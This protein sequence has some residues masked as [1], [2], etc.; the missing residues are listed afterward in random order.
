MTTAL[1]PKTTS[2]L[3][4]K[5]GQSVFSSG[6]HHY[7]YAFLSRYVDSL[8]GSPSVK[9]GD[10]S[11]GYQRLLEWGKRSVYTDL[12]SIC[13][14]PVVFFPDGVHNP[15]LI[16]DHA[17]HTWL[18]NKGRERVTDSD[19]YKHKVE[20]YP[21]L[22]ELSIEHFFFQYI[23]TSEIQGILQEAIQDI[24]KDYG[25][26][27]SPYKY[28]S[29]ITKSAITDT[30]YKRNKDFAP[31]AFQCDTVDH[32]AG[33]HLAHQNVGAI[34][35]LSAPTRSGKSHMG[36]MI[37]KEL[38]HTQDTSI[39][40]IVSGIA[41]VRTEWQA[42]WESHKDFEGYHFYTVDDLKR[43]PYLIDEA[44]EQGQDHLVVFL[45]L[46]DLAGSNKDDGIKAA[47][48]FLRDHQVDVILADE[49]HWAALSDNARKLNKSIRGYGDEKAQDM[50]STSREYTGMSKKNTQ[51]TTTMLGTVDSRCG[52]VFIT[53]TPY[54]SLLSNTLGFND[55]NKVIITK[56]DIKA[57]A[58][59]WLDENP[60]IP[61]YLSPYFGL[62]KE[63]TL[64]LPIG[65]EVGEFFAS[66]EKGFVHQQ[67]V[68]NLFL[69]M[70]GAQHH[71]NY[72][73]ILTDPIYQ[74][75][76]LGN[77]IIITLDKKIAC[78][79]LEDILDGA[80]GDDYEVLNISSARGG[81]FSEPKMNT[82][83]VK[84]YIKNTTKKP[85]VI[86]VDK[87][88]TGSTVEKIDTVI[89]AR[90]LSSAQAITQYV[91]RSN[92]PYVVDMEGEDGEHIK[93]C[94][95]QNSATIVFDPMIAVRITDNDMRYEVDYG[96]QGQQEGYIESAQRQ[97]AQR[98]ILMI[99]PEHAHLHE[100][101]AHDVLSTLHQYNSEVGNTMSSMIHS[102]SINLGAV[103]GDAELLEAFSNFEVFA[104][105]SRDVSMDYLAGDLGDH[106]VIQD[107]ECLHCEGSIYCEEHLKEIKKKSD[108]MENI[109][110]G[111]N[112]TD[113]D[114]TEREPTKEE[115]K[116]VKENYAELREKV[117][118]TAMLAMLY[119]ILNT[120]YIQGIQEAIASM[121]K[122][123]NTT[124]VDHM[125]INVHLLERLA[126]NGTFARSLDL[127]F[128]EAEEMFAHKHDESPIERY[129]LALKSVGAFSPNEVMTPIKVANMLVDKVDWDHV[130]E[131]TTFMDNGCKSGVILAQA[132]AKMLEVGVDAEIVGNNLYCVPT[133][134]LTYEIIYK[135]YQ[136]YGWNT[137]NILYTDG[138]TALEMNN[139]MVGWIKRKKNKE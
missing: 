103:I 12:E 137:D 92:T 39:T 27:N 29:A 88:M 31:R 10:T 87:M 134:G 83:Q 28:Y 53:A 38:T 111:E 110:D 49:A 82:A 1:A 109:I 70:F 18:V 42:T 117:H 67:E 77:G 36:A 114:G 64:V 131:S 133:S 128:I 14:I 16:R 56:S 73:N 129:M 8:L 57:E 102:D 75:A 99:D 40:L 6:V 105:G 52:T 85:V 108:N 62:V 71:D 58:D 96:N 37:A 101:S 121:K 15:V 89:L 13:M 118:N 46:Q 44:R 115:V 79:H 65:A 4:D 97:L 81:R 116:E 59:R 86:T 130:D 123:E 94:I 61:A 68:E 11:R 132:Y 112:I 126:H 21:R 127:S 2:M 22:K 63:H 113:D 30:H 51:A 98:P 66:T 93:E 122:P 107:C 104:G 32:L 120:D 7:V 84:E 135:I 54:N 34:S 55:D 91:G 50:M 138:I 23:H 24:I 47:H 76:R 125:G 35:L 60:K 124:M 69:G 20:K 139:Y 72:P 26:P 80:I 45:T 74:N 43:N 95:K 90:H 5:D 136:D 78:D 106:C 33:Y 48:R 3:L 25:K 9:V 41:G 19:L 17:I 119:A 100:F